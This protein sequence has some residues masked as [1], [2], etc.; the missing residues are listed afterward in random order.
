MTCKAFAELV[1]AKSGSFA[2]TSTVT[3][4]MIYGHVRNILTLI[5]LF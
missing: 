2:I 3:Q 5:P 1:E 4:V